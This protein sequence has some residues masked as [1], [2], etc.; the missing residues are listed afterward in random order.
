MIVV[1]S[2]LNKLDAATNG[3]R[4]FNNL[5]ALS[6]SQAALRTLQPQAIG[7]LNRLVPLVLTSNYYSH[8]PCLVTC[9]KIC[10]K[11]NKYQGHNLEQ[12]DRC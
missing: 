9:V 10:C 6:S 3:I 11:Q 1:L 4:Q 7:L 5:Q 12:Y 2:S 8:R